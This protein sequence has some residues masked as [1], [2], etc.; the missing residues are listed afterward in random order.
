MKQEIF[1]KKDK[2]DKTSTFYKLLFSTICVSS[3][4]SFNTTYASSYSNG[5]LEKSSATYTY[6]KDVDLDTYGDPATK[7]VTTSATPPS[8]YVKDGHD[9]NDSD[10][11]INPKATEVCD[12]IDNNCDGATDDLKS[13]TTYYYRDADKDGYGNKSV[14]TTK[15]TYPQY[16]VSSTDCNDSNAN[17]YPLATELCD[18]KDNDCDAYT[19]EGLTSTSNYYYSDLDKDGYGSGTTKTYTKCASGYSSLATDCNDSKNTVYPG[20]PDSGDTPDALD[21][22]CDTYVDDCDGRSE[23]SGP[24]VVIVSP[25]RGSFRTSSSTTVSGYVLPSKGMATISTITVDGSSVTPTTCSAQGGKKFSK[26]VTA[27]KGVDTI[28]VIATDASKFSDKALV[29]TIY[30]DYFT[31]LATYDVTKAVSGMFNQGTWNIL[32]DYV[33][34]LLPDSEIED[35]L[36]DSNPIVD[37]ADYDVTNDELACL[38]YY[39]IVAEID[40]YKHSD[41]S[42]TFTITGGKVKAVATIKN[43]ELEMSGIANY[44]LDWWCTGIWGEDVP[45][46]ADAV[47][48]S[49]SATSYGA[50][51]IKNGKLDVSFSS[52]TV[53][54]SGMTVDVYS[55]D[56]WQDFIIWIAEMFFSDEDIAEMLE[57]FLKDMIEG[58]VSGCT[59]DCDLEDFLN[60]FLNP[61]MTLDFTLGS[62]NY[63]VAFGY[64]SVSVPTGTTNLSMNM[65]IDYTKA[66][67]TPTNSGF[68]TYTS[69]TYSTTQTSP[70]FVLKSSYNFFNAGLH[71]LW[72]GGVLNLKN[73]GVDSDGD[74]DNDATVTT[75]SLL[76]PVVTSSSTSGYLLKVSFGE[77]LFDMDIDIGTGTPYNLLLATSANVDLNLGIQ[78]SGNELWFTFDFVLSSVDYDYIDNAMVLPE[79]EAVIFDKAMQSVSN[80]LLDLATDYLSSLHIDYADVPV[81]FSTFKVLKD[82]SNSAMLSVEAT[83]SYSN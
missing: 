74:G 35:L 21:N 60:D 48:T 19:D 10:S 67:G 66:S 40:S 31:S 65:G 13:G 9:C 59:G 56:W 64:N 6:Y 68:V 53:S 30:S 63:D 71:A 24:E 14:Y 18:G 37:E 11:K 73:F 78:F 49:L 72:E 20:A 58:T 79:A 75:T 52:T 39:D 5:S 80:K 42:V 27:S 69:T 62:T 15:C 77:M 22:D 45:I 61:N 26:T 83:G 12:G 81:K 4:V 1:I 47:A 2:I 36:Q 16:V 8:G 76:P 70:T 50:L 25:S 41:F 55:T 34:D 28:P 32:A 57:D 7:Q 3:V 51:A 82:T 29:S 54:S 17:A 23:G 46:Y 44:G 33:E 43:P 38:S